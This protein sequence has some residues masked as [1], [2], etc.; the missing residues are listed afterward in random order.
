[1][2][3][4]AYRTTGKTGQGKGG[5]KLT[6]IFNQVTKFAESGPVRNFPSAL[7]ETDR[8]LQKQDTE[9]V[10]VNEKN[11]EEVRRPT[12]EA[13]LRPSIDATLQTRD[14]KIKEPVSTFL[15]IPS[16]SLTFDGISS[17]DNAVAF[18][19]QFAPPDT[20]G[21]VGPN[22]YVETV[23]NLVRV[24]DK[25]GVP[26]TP[27]FKQS[28]LFAP[29]GGL[30]SQVDRGDPIVLYD[31]MAD[32]WL[33][34]QF[35][36]SGS[37]PNTPP[38]HIAIAISKTGD[39]TGAYYLYDFVTPSVTVPAPGS[40][41]PD[42]FK[43][44]AWPDGY[45]M[46]ANQ[47]FNGG[48]FNGTGAY[49]FDRKK[50]L[51]GDSTANQIYFNLDLASHPEGIFG[52]L[53]SDTEGLLPP[54]VGAP[55]I[56]AYFT[57]DEFGDPQDGLRLFNFHADFGTPANSTFTE[58]PE[59]TY[60]NPLP[61]AAFDPRDPP[62]RSD[63][64][65]PPP[66]ENL[67]AVASRLMHR[68]QYLNRGGFESLVTNFTVNVSG[69]TPNT[70]ANYQAS[71]RYFELRSASVGGLFSVNE[72]ATIPPATVSGATGENRWM[73]S[74]A[75]DNQG[76]LSVGY[77][78]SSTTVRPDIRY[79][80]RLATD[81]PGGLFQGEAIMFSGTG[82]QQ[83][84]GGRWG[85]YSA[86]QLDP[87]DDCTFWY[88]NEYYAVNSSFNWRTRIGRF[89][90]A[91][92]TAPAQGVLTGIITACDTGAPLQFALIEV[93]GGPSNGFSAATLANGTYTMH[94]APGTYTVNVSAVG[95]DCNPAGPFTVTITD[96]GTTTL[97]ACLSG[98]AKPIFSS[99][100]ISGGNGNGVI[101]RNECN[102]LTVAI[103][104]D[105]CSTAANVS[106]TISSSTPGVTITQPNS[107]YPNI[108]VNGVATNLVPFSVSTSASFVCGTPI[109]FTMTVT[110][111]G[112]SSTF[113]FSLP[114]CTCP[115]TTITGSL[116]AGDLQQ[117]AR[118]GRDGVT[119]GCGTSKVCPGPLGAGPRLYDIYSFTNGGGVTACATITLTAGCS[120]ATN[121]IIA[122]AYL[123]SFNPA[124][125]CTNYLGDP[126]GSPNPTNSF[127]VNV[128]AGGTLLVNVHEINP[129]LLGCSSYT[130]T[131][132]G[133]FCDTPG[134]GE[135]VPCTISCPANIVQSNAPNQCGAT[136]SYPA[137]TSGGTC[138][139]VSCTPPS[140]AFFP[141]GTT[142][143]TCSTTAGPS[144]SFTVRINDT[145]KPVVSCSTGVTSM[146]ARCAL[147]NVR[148]SITTSD[149]CPNSTVSVRVFSDE[150]DV[151]P[152]GGQASP[153]A[154][155]TAPNT[156]LLRADR[157][158]SGNGRVYLVIVT[159][160]D[161]SGNV[162]RCC[163]TVTVPFDQ[164]A[165]AKQSV[166]NQ[167][168]AARIFCE[169]NGTAP[170][171]FFLVGDGPV[172]NCE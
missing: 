114:T 28:T 128:P 117:T 112:G 131:V 60:A 142:T 134:S 147:V 125:L 109:T 83:A 86:M 15:N 6:P 75:A 92:C 74:A 136:V 45:Y 135:C 123:G 124:N 53:P 103:K 71:V 38:Y 55:N 153:D 130:L 77:S 140:G 141:V 44:G 122:V 11:T 35:A 163:L 36:F 149:N 29:L 31:R 59:S 99:A 154:V 78:L 164:S 105:G 169:Q 79:A 63:V 80:G 168:T 139:V 5:Q 30:V 10:E 81:P 41:F 91:T 24:Y 48:G 150:D 65:E 17:A 137:P 20:N 129:G 58:R 1:M 155:F 2:P 4:Q 16:P 22:H 68:M 167:A 101:D 72:Q 49:A 57:A 127:S 159:V 165:A 23:N 61:L 54:P 88:T 158:N 85:D 69:V 3:T 108:P 94:L 119:S 120:P 34:S 52:M 115:P 118:L 110:F 64:E 62:G 51:V 102:N 42:Y 43:I 66:G 73:A 76:N 96:G 98:S 21:D 13:A 152:G 18:G 7:K 162:S 82:V 95:H 151:E 100:T 90:F 157:K 32:R 25:N 106:A 104:N 47:F 9:G 50:M 144:C 56:F 40:N 33:I 70:A 89:K 97:S 148:L 171:A 143:V 87:S 133:L 161:A 27:P 138:G 126:G 67:D 93:S 170:P 84:T 14:G 121:P 107:P 12:A 39:P 113:T 132:S 19:V 46:T 156:L 8:I 26:L 37:L 166:A 116:T 145:Q 111:T 146:P 160:T 172:V